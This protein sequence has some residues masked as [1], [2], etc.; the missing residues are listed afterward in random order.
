[1]N[2]FKNHFPNLRI[3]QTP[4]LIISLFL[5]AGCDSEKKESVEENKPTGIEIVTIG[6]DFQMKD[7]I[8][9]GWNT[10]KYENR[11]AE[12]HFFLLE[13]Y[14][15]GKTIEDGKKEVIPV[16]Q[17][18]MDLIQEGKPKEAFAEF[19]KLPGWYS[20][21]IFSGGSGMVSPGRSST[22]ILKLD[23]GYYVMECYVKMPNGK[24]HSAMG[25]LKAIRVI[26]NE[27]GNEP[28]ESTVNVSISSTE[29][30]TFDSSI[31]K[32]KHVFK[33][34]FKDQIVHENFLGH[35]INLVKLES[36]ANTGILEKWMNWSDP[37]GLISPSPAG[38]LFM[39]G[40]NEMQAGKTGYFE[41]NLKPGKYAFISEVPKSSVKNM[42]KVFVITDD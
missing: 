17:N 31:K 37:A 24:F 33:V 29:G 14:P 1:M 7:S 3:I 39:G 35:D 38:V 41:V 13:K 6:M 12:T 10:F 34:T 40:V 25:M 5:F 28:P 4:A 8:A 20:E 15:D 18:G 16:F 32:G 19:G 21:I 27:S 2:F 11:S 26:V 23:P 9:S 36:N 42:L 30:I 22:T